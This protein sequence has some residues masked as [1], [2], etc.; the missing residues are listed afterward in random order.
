MGDAQCNAPLEAV[1]PPCSSGCTCAD[2]M[3]C[4]SDVVLSLRHRVREGQVGRH[5]GTCAQRA[6][7]VLDKPIAEGGRI[8]P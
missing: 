3:E 1:G 4:C 2:G 5:D 8:H 7:R 6:V